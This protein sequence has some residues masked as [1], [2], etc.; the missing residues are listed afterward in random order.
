MN[1]RI[2]YERGDIVRW[3]TPFD[4]ETPQGAEI[5]VHHNIEGSAGGHVGAQ[6]PER[7]IVVFYSDEV[8]SVYFKG[9]VK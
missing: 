3:K 5:E 2:I 4:H 6:I 7:K 8:E 1:E 9:S